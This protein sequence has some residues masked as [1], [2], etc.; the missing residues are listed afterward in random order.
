MGFVVDQI[1]IANRETIVRPRATV[2]DLLA[3]GG[4]VG[5]RC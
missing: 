1:T 5:A 3:R 2:A 4:I